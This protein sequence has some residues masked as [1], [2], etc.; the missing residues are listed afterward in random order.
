MAGAVMARVAVRESVTLVGRA[1]RARVAR[2]F[3]GE[4]LGAGHPCGEVSVLLVSELFSNSLRHSQSGTPGGTVTI[5]VTAGGGIV[6]VEVTDRSGPGVPELRPS[7]REAE[8]GRG[9]LLVEGL[10]AQWGWQR[11]GE[12][13]VTWF[14]L[15]HGSGNWSS[16]ATW[17]SPSG[18]RR[19][20]VGEHAR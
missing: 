5:T 14:A 19:P 2:M 10:A 1:E 11:L 15:R 17:N 13:T 12:H 20:D 9:L 18:T 16:A 7:G 4:V 3:A 8:A 6:R